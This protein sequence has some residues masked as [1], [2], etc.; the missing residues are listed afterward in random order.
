MCNIGPYARIREGS[1]ILD[2]AKVGNFVET[3]KS[4][5]GKGSK[6]NHFSYLGDST[7]GDDANIG[8][9]AITCNYDGK[10]KYVTTIGNNAFIGSNSFISCTC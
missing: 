8:A 4:I 5:I 3:K 6:A 7:I 2:E 9:G 10:N 1:E